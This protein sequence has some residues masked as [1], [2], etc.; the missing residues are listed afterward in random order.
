MADCRC[1]K[2]VRYGMLNQARGEFL[3]RLPDQKYAHTQLTFFSPFQK[4]YFSV[5]Q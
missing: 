2:M 4:K 3:V 1:P 5:R